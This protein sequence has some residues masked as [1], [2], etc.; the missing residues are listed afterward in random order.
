MKFITIALCKLLSFLGKLLGRGSSLP[1]S[2]ALKVCPNIL[3]RLTLPEHVIAVTGA[4]GKTST[5]EMIAAALQKAGKKVVYNKEGSNQ[6]EG[7]TT[8]LLNNA[9]LSGKVA[10]DIVLLES[11]ERFARLTFKHIKPTVFIVTNLYRDQM[12]R[13]TILLDEI[14]NML[15]DAI[16]DD[17]A[18][19]IYISHADC[20]DDAAYVEKKVKE[21]IPEASVYLNYIG[22]IIGA[23][24]GPGAIALFGT[25]RPVTV[26]G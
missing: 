17:R 9:S 14:V 12:T 19:C 13:N 3:S 20:A 21:K 11:D 26:A 8:L 18:Q 24:I 15:A 7:V 22:P 1:G 25:G 23:S 16:G 5:V 6:I 10:G 2:I 4:N